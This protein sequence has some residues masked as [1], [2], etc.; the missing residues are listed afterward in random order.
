[1]RRKKSPK[2]QEDPDYDGQVEYAYHLDAGLLASYLKEKGKLEGVNHVIDNVL[3]VC[4][5]ERGFIQ[6]LITE[7]HGALDGELFIDCSGFRGLLINQILKEPF[8]SYSDSLLCDRAIALPMHY[9][10]EDP[11]NQ[12]HGGINPYTTATALSSGW[13]WNIPLVKRSGTGY[14]YSSAFISDEDAEAE[15]KQH[16]GEK[17]KELNARLIKMRVGRNQNTWVKNCVSIGLSSGFI[18]PL[19]STGIYLIEVGI[20]NLIHNF[21]N[22]LFEQAVI[23]NYNQTMQEH[24][25]EIRDFIVMHYCLTKRED[26]KFWQE[27]KYLSA[28]PESLKNKLKL[29]QA[30]WPNNKQKLSKLFPDYSYICILAGMGYFPKNSLPILD[31]QSDRAGELS[32]ANIKSKANN[33]TNSLPNHS[34]YIKNIQSKNLF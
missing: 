15:F 19:E 7:N 29:W 32:L 6:H 18:E 16:L 14:V 20:E 30:M 11:Y 8:I 13:V 1:M 27:N 22:Q 4:L 31:F 9:D 3:D 33:L 2:Y 23:N 21:P 24:Y 28:I 25:E 17:S 26:S 10:T 12:N 5:D 34:D